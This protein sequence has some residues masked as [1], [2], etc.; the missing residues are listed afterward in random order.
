MAK[1]VL[2]LIVVLIAVGA[3]YLYVNSGLMVKYYIEQNGSAATGVQVSVE[4]VELNIL[5]GQATLYGL[6]VANPEGFSDAAA[7]SAGVIA[8][9]LDAN[10]VSEKVMTITGVRV[11]SPVFVYESVDGVSNYDIIGQN[12]QSGTGAPARDNEKAQKFIVDL[13]AFSNGQIKGIGLSG[14]A[15]ERVAV[16]P[17]FT[18]TDLGKAEG[19]VGAATIASR[20]ADVV[21]AWVVEAVVVGEVFGGFDPTPDGLSGDQE[22]V[23]PAEGE[24]EG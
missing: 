12:A 22:G 20:L 10:T 2:I 23:M 3:G 4:S 6:R 13:I 19:G 1:R 18:I 11:V 24:P 14:A 9:N 17:G 8:V 7:F 16:L 15:E 5:N 21:T